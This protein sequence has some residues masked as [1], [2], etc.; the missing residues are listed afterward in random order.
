MIHLLDESSGLERALVATPIRPEAQR[1]LIWRVFASQGSSRGVIV[2]VRFLM[3]STACPLVD[4][5]IHLKLC[6]RLTG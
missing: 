4:F 6:L 5:A 2:G 1:C 3:A